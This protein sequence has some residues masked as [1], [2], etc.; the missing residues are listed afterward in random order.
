MGSVSFSFDPEP[1]GE[2]HRRRWL[3]VKR[4]SLDRRS[5]GSPV[6]LLFTARSIGYAES[7]IGERLGKWVIFKELGRGG[8]GRVYLAQE[9][10]TGQQAAIKVLAAELALDAGFL[11]RFY[12]EIESLSRLDHPNVVRFYEAGVENHRHFYAMEYVEGESLEMILQARGK[13]PWRE[14]LDIASQLAPALRHVHDHG[15]IHR[16]LKPPN[17]LRTP[18]GIVKLTDFGI[19]KVF[20]SRHLTATGGVIGTAEFLSPEQAAGKA[21]GKGSDLYCLGAVLYTLLTGRPP[22]QGK[23]HVE[24]LHKHRYGQFDRPARLVPEIPEEVDDLICQLLEKEPDNRPRD[25]HVLGKQLEAIRRRLDRKSQHTEASQREEVTQV[26]N[27]V[28]LNQLENAEGPATLM[29]RLVRSELQREAEGG[30]VARILNRPWVLVSLLALCIAILV[31]AFW[32]LGQDQLFE[33]GA[34][35]MKTGEI[36]DMERAWSEY[37]GPLESRFPDHP[38]HEEV[39]RYRQLLEVAR[40]PR[41][42]EAQRFYQQG[43]QL[44]QQGNLHAAAQTWRHLI[45]AFDGLDTERE[46]VHRAERALTDLEKNAANPDRFKEA[47]TAL[48]RAAVLDRDGKRADAERIWTALEALYRD[49]PGAAQLLTEIAQA[50]KR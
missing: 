6:W 39:Q 18:Q 15:I 47:R 3:R 46:W 48:E 23:S 49:D 20:A 7:M 30:P 45:A 34:Q 32:P 40:S 1:N 4:H 36:V 8:M 13:L 12:R 50:R 37:F 19:A 16:D 42:S 29:S 38:Y 44:R 26:D 43:E 22:F 11:Q 24:L 2:D 21:V 9:E 17:V 35:L 14:V 10:L 5:Y 31:W 27:K 25:C 28:E 41:Q 33:R